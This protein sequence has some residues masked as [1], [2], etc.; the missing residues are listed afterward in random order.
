LLQAQDLQE[1]TGDIARRRR[2]NLELIRLR[3]EAG[4]EH[5]GALLSAEASLIEAEFELAQAQR[6][7]SLAQTVLSK[8]MGRPTVQHVEVTGEFAVDDA[9]QIRPDFAGIADSVPFLQQLA[10]QSEA[11]RFGLK[12]ARGAWLPEVFVSSSVG[13][14]S[15]SWPPEETEWSAGLGVSLPLFDG[16]RR[17]AIQDRRQAQVRKAQAQQRSGRDSVI[18]TLEET[19]AGLQDALGMVSVRRKFLDAAQ[20]RASIAQTQY[21]TGLIDFDDWT[22]IED[23]LVQ[24]KKAYLNA[25]S[26]MLLAEARWLQAKGRILENVEPR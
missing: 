21:S 3:Y 19:W 6:E 11:A 22:I 17:R 26:N 10:A 7:L 14:T 18:V 13:D 16:G 2:Q 15:D 1:L 5:R 24:A 4:R 12:S 20:E 9:V 8:A 25:Q 23:N